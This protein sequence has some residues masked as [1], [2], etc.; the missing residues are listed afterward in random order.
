MSVRHLTEATILDDS[1]VLVTIWYVDLRTLGDQTR[2]RSLVKACRSEHAISELGTIRISKPELFRRF[3][4]GLIKDTAET[5]VSRTV[6]TSEEVDDPD[7]LK[8]AQRIDDELGRCAAAIGSPHRTST[9]NCKTTNSNWQ[10]MNFGKNGWIYSTSIEPVGEEEDHK[11]K[12][13]LPEGYDHVDRIHRPREFARALGSM[14]VEQIGPLCK[15]QSVRQRTDG[16]ESSYFKYKG[17]LIVHGPVV[18]AED[19]FELVS[20]ARTPMERMCLPIFLKNSRYA[21]QREYRFAIWS[22]DEPSQDCVDLT[23]SNTL[24]GS[25]ETRA[26]LPATHVRTTTNELAAE[27]AQPGAGTHAEAGGGSGADF[28]AMP[29]WPAWPRR[30]VANRTSGR[31]IPWTNPEFLTATVAEV[32]AAEAALALPCHEIFRWTAVFCLFML[33]PWHSPRSSAHCGTRRRF[34]G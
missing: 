11:W 4:E 12:D 31:T 23:A 33:E 2:V 20:S 5:L 28:E 26:S 14:V 24:F 25:L 10:T 1:D 19:P 30:G 13:S 34:P 16:G 17:Q 22:E 7:D 3:G 8:A 21:D 27:T 6:V 29:L 9:T 15:E 32:A 18:Y